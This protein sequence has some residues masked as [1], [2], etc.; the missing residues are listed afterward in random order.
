M[1]RST[2]EMLEELKK[3]PSFRKELKA[4]IKASKSVYKL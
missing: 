4:F 3:D 2:A 1:A